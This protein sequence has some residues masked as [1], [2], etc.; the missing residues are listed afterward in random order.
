MGREV[1][2]DEL[3]SEI[4]NFCQKVPESKYWEFL[5]LRRGILSGKNYLEAIDDL[6]CEND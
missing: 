5:R 2:A 3:S 1:S 4:V 6:E